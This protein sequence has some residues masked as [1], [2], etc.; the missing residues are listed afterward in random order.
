MVF[1]DTFNNI[2]VISWWPVLLVEETGVPRENHRPVASNWQK[3]YHLLLYRVHLAWAGFELTT[4]VV[5]GTDCIGSYKSNYH[6]ITTT[7]APM[8]ICCQPMLKQTMAAMNYSLSKELNEFWHFG[9]SDNLHIHIH[10]YQVPKLYY[11]P[12]YTL[13]NQ[14]MLCCCGKYRHIP[15]FY[16]NIMVNSI[17]H[18]SLQALN[19]C[20]WRPMTSCFK[21]IR[22][23]WIHTKL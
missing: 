21:N 1:N 4:S 20:R 8:L 23:S 2:S 13:P 22:L 5:I 3:L 17:G 14:I 19:I 11:I 15:V 7:T 9:T 10:V 6:T 18:I 12:T 16:I